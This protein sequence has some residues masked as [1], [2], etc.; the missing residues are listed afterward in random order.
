M[1]KEQRAAFF[2]TSEKRNHGST[3]QHEAARSI[4][5]AT[6]RGEQ[7]IRETRAALA[8]DQASSA[9]RKAAAAAATAH[10]ADAIEALKAGGGLGFN[11]LAKK[12]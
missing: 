9:N 5:E 7:Q 10:N 1:T 4:R 6:A 2:G 3:P 8:N 12:R 11:P